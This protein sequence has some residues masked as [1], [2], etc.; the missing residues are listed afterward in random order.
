[1]RYLILGCGP[2]AIAAAKAIRK[3]SSDARI[4]IV[5]EETEVPYLRPLLTDLL[6]GDIRDADIADPQG[7]DLGALQIEVVRGRRAEA[8]DP[9][10]KTVRFGD[11]T[12]ERYDALL[13][14]TGGKPAVPPALSAGGAAVV[15]FDSLEDA[16]RIRAR[17]GFP[18]LAA[19]YGPGFLGIVT[20][21]ALRKAGREVVW[22]RPDLPRYGYPLEG[23]LEASILD[24]V[25]NR[26]VR[27]ADGVDVTAA[28]DLGESGVL[29]RTSGREE[30]RCGVAVVATERVPAA[31]FLSGSGVK[32]GAGI[33]VGDDLRTSVPDVYAAGDC[34][35]VVDRESGERMINFGWRSAVKQGRLAG[36]NMS[37]AGK[38]Y[39][40]TREDYFWLLF[41]LPLQ[42]RTR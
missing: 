34:A 31:R 17:L 3:R 4:L 5:T 18:G 12:Q 23:E 39:I 6:A 15:P 2:A 41:G 10:G 9:E 27:I 35:E 32:V 36:E 19:V 8:V 29:L 37:G 7:Q 33:L 26:G 22:I 11:G 20:C 28:E 1:M 24:D 42:E 16:R 25:R 21:L 13:V 38:A 40:R 30:I 14:A